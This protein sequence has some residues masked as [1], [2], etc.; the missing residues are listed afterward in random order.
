MIT[1]C[2]KCGGFNGEDQSKD[3]HCDC[4]IVPQTMV[5]D[6]YQAVLNNG[7]AND[8]TDWIGVAVDLVKKGYKKS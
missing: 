7:T 1:Q 8:S 2:P 3:V 5:N 6:I 4:P